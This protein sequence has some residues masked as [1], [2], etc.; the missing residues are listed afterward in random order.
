M[1]QSLK[2]SCHAINH[3]DSVVQVLAVKVT[4]VGDHL[5]V[6]ELA[7]LL[8]EIGVVLDYLLPCDH[9]KA[10]VHE[11]LHVLPVLLVLLLDIALEEGHQQKQLQQ[12]GRDFLTLLHLDLGAI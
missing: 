9:R 7:L 1:P 6:H 2:F 10:A 5:L 11:V 12:E 4:D 8:L 3:G